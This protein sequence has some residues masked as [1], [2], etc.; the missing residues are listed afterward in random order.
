M[1]KNT[2]TTEQ[3]AAAEAAAVINTTA[4]DT[5]NDTAP[6]TTDGAPLPAINNFTAG[7]N[8]AELDKLAESNRDDLIELTSELLK[9]EA[10]EQFIG[11][12]TNQIEMIESQDADGQPYEAVVMYHRNK[13]KV[14]CADAV[15]VSTAKKL[16]AGIPSDQ[17]AFK[18]VRI[19]CHG[20]RKS[21]SNSK[22]EYRDLKILAL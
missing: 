18:A 11:Y 6:A 1:A 16:F 22:N 21:S 7:F 14:I 3:D 17:A 12:M 5:A 10:G 15:A 19:E 8:T 9:L 20:M 13:S 2:K 4:T